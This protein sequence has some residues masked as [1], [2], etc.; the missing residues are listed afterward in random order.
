LSP[1]IGFGGFC[2]PKD[3][4]AFIRIAETSGCDFSLLKEVERVNQ[5]R[6][7][8]FVKKLRDE[9]WVVRGKKLAV[10]G[11]AFKPNT[12]DVRFAPSIALIQALLKEGATVR[13][14]DPEAMDKAKAD[15]P[16]IEYCQDPY[17][18]AQGADAILIV[19]EWEQFR[20]LDW[21]RLKGIVEQPLIL[22]GRNMFDPNEVARNGFRYVSVGR[23]STSSVDASETEV[24]RA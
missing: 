3:V 13:A 14:Y 4:Q 8:G 16:N 12:D 2:F 15:L 22:D 23:V 6:I 20:N 21:R 18:A 5:G 7:E 24:A 9:L 19:T 11:L 17:E 10:W 1:G